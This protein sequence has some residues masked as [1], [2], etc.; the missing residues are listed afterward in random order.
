[1]TNLYEITGEMRDLRALGEIEGEL[2]VKDTLDAIAGEFKNKA[3]AIVHISL[4]L[5]GDV[6]SIK[7]EIERLQDRKKA[8]E[9]RDKSLKEYLRENMEA[10]G[11][12]KISCPLFTITLAAGRSIAIIENESELPDEMVEVKTEIVPDKAKILAALKSGQDVAGASLGT[13][14]SSIRIK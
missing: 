9:S 3:E 6:D 5:N 1:M 13:S 10:A 8:I 12:S 11:I 7:N 14:K 2:V 4:N